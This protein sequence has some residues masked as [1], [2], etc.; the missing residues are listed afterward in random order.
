MM[1]VDGDHAETTLRALH[2]IAAIARET[3]G[4]HEQDAPPP[5]SLSF[6]RAK[7]AYAAR[8]LRN[9]AFGETNELF[10][11][12]GWDMLL[13]LFIASHEGRRVC[14]S[15]ACIAACVPHSTAMRYVSVLERHGLIERIQDPTD[16]RRM[17]LELTSRARKYMGDALRDPPAA[18]GTA[19]APEARGARRQ[20]EDQRPDPIIDAI[21]DGAAIMTARLG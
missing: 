17:F 10:E 9:K 16:R 12:P 4:R 3:I 1:S 2:R 20:P 19:P 8:R 14:V 13:D 18:S 15:N 7:A 11:E 6:V 21:P 5:A